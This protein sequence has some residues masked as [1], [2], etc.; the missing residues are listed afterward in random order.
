MK[1]KKMHWFGI[2]SG[3]IAIILNFIFFYKESQIFMFLM[4]I[5]LLILALPFVIGLSLENKAEQKVNDMFLEFS[6]NLAES[7]ATGTP[8][9]KAIINMKKKN[10]GLLNPHIS[11]LAN[12][13]ELGIPLGE[14]LHNFSEDVGSKVINR[15][16][17]LIEEAE[18]AGGEIDYILDSTAKSISEIEILKKERKSAIYTLVV[19]G[20]II[21]FIFIGI[22]LVMQFKI[23]PLTTGIG[24]FTGFTQNLNSLS[25][26]AATQ[27]T[28]LDADQFTRPFLY[29]LL[30]QGFFVGLVIGKVTEGSIK[31]G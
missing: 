15:A 21:F 20:Y 31:K 14:A 27:N 4:G 11:K 29:L 30:T 26:K 6:R 16:I 12:Q 8:V 1:L 17:A 10:Y 13:I 25:G 23:I 19:Q 24:S 18:R 7:V 28:A 5:A 9:S 2:I 22:V 3:A